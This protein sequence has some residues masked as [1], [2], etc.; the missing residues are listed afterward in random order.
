[1]EIARYVVPRQVKDANAEFAYRLL[2]DDRA[3]DARVGSSIGPISTKDRERQLVPSS[4]TDLLG[5]LL[6]SSNGIR[7][8]RG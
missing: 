6:A 4:V 1:M 2:V 5:T 3:D 8:L 7:L